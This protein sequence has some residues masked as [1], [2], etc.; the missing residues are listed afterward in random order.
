MQ[1]LDSEE[2]I[3][4]ISFSDGFEKKFKIKKNLTL[5]PEDFIQILEPS[6]EY[7]GL[8]EFLSEENDYIRTIP[9]SDLPDFK[10]EE[11]IINDSIEDAVLNFISNIYIRKI[12]DGAVD[13][14]TMLI[15]PSRIKIDINK[16]TLLI[17]SLKNKIVGDIH[18]GKAS[19]TFYL[20]IHTLIQNKSKI[21]DIDY[22]ILLEII[23]QIEIITFHSG[24]N[25]SL[26]F[27]ILRDRILIGGDKLSRGFT[28][29]GLSVT[30]FFR[31]SSRLD[32][33][34]QMARWFGYRVGFE[35]LIKIYMTEEDRSYFEF[36]GSVDSDL[37]DQIYSMN[38]EESNPR[39]F[40]LSM[41]YNPAYL[42]YNSD[43][44]R[45]MDLTDPNKM[46]H[47]SIENRVSKIIGFRRLVNNKNV[48]LQNLKYTLDWIESLEENYDLVIKSND[49]KKLVGNDNNK[50]FINV[51]TN[52]VIDLIDNLKFYENIITDNFLT[53]LKNSIDT[54]LKDWSVMISRPKTS[55]YENEYM[56]ERTYSLDDDNVYVSSVSSGSSGVE[57]LF[58]L[59]EN[60]SEIKSFEDQ[61]AKG[62]KKT[63]LI[64]R[65]R[66]AKGR[67]L[68]KVFI[69]RPN[70]E[71]KA[72]HE[73]KISESVQLL[74]I[75][76]D[77]QSSNYVRRENVQKH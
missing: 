42:G 71:S 40:G 17:Q 23:E 53:D 76:P 62:V 43:T 64:N 12:L 68:L 70:K 15:H 30:Y 39:D 57:D 54:K 1:H 21:E 74:L 6:S 58:D 19:S 47:F 27:K 28:I 65:L 37:N 66:K 18:K 61:L 33:L 48:N 29:E 52:H 50:K 55:K 24:S 25:D 3:D 13:N 41:I 32:S 72:N 69:S 73:I 51:S 46:R 2:K 49:Y 31:R 4:N 45:R 10:S 77:K 63:V 59:I 56:R 5:Y 7:L 36:M 8:S 34:H 14:N 75:L 9:D 20:K 26:N 11:L 44:K 35:N 22:D 60:E 67:P 16:Y 38:F